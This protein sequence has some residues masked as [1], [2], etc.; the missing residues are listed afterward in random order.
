VSKCIQFTSKVPIEEPKSQELEQAKP[1]A[2][3]DAGF[4]AFVKN[5][6][7]GNEPMKE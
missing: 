6:N 7:N 1:T 3:D 2:D 4:A 5:Y